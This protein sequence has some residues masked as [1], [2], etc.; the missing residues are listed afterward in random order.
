MKEENITVVSVT[1]ET[2]EKLKELRSA[3]SISQRRIVEKL[4]NDN[5]AAVMNWHK[6]QGGDIIVENE[7]Q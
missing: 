5:Y 1:I 3:T 6:K 7:K 4:V 2:H